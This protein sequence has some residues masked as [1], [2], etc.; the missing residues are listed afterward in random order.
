MDAEGFLIAWLNANAS[1]PAYG[2]VPAEEDKPEAFLTVERTGGP[3]GRDGIDRP[4]LAVQCWA[5]S[6]GAAAAL[7]SEVALLA[8]AFE[9][10][11]RVASCSVNSLHRHPTDKKEPRYQVVMDAEIYI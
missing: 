2:R 9:G 5:A 11:D 10:E 3:R 4:M 1:A 8:E 7:A 6:D